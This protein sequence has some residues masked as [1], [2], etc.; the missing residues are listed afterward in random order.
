MSRT[1][2]H[3]LSHLGYGRQR[4]WRWSGLPRE[5]RGRP[6]A[7]EAEEPRIGVVVPGLVVKDE[8][9][10][11]WIA[12]VADGEGGAPVGLHDRAV[13]HGALVDLNE[14]VASDHR[15]PQEGI[16]V[17]AREHHGVVEQP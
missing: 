4:R 16:G 15:C 2:P 13:E 6:E 8:A 14:E 3:D 10:G 5:V 11:L 7:L 12:H 9:R 1:R 17:A